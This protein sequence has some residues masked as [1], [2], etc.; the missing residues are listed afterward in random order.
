M[1]ACV[2]VLVLCARATEPN[3]KTELGM[4]KRKTPKHQN[5]PLKICQKIEAK[6]RKIERRAQ[7]WKEKKDKSFPQAKKVS[8]SKQKKAKG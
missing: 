4:L 7:N 2:R 8:S 5:F 3:E 1:G 6:K